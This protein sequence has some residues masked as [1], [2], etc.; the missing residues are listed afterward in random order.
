MGALVLI[1][2]AVLVICP[3]ALLPVLMIVAIMA[4]IGGKK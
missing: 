3:P 1:I 4:M 2:L